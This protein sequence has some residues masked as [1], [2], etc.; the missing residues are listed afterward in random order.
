MLVHSG[1]R[2]LGESILGSYMDTV[3]GGAKGSEVDK[4]ELKTYLAGH[5]LALNFAKRNRF[6]IAHRILEQIPSRKIKADS[7]F[8]VN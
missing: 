1:S 8:A 2:S 7:A 4:E 3:G 5:D 6:L